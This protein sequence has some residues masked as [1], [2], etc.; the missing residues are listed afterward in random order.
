MNLD[1]IFIPSDKNIISVTEARSLL[2]LFYA[3]K[4]IQKDDLLQIEWISVAIDKLKNI[5]ADDMMA[6]VG[7]DFEQAIIK[8]IVEEEITKELNS[9][10]SQLS[11]DNVNKKNQIVF[12]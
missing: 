12:L 7:E 9:K 2:P 10:N 5:I 1:I 4:E 3:I 6:E 8:E 11:K